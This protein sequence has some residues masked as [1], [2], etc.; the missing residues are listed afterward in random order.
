M[1][2][3]QIL[4]NEDSTSSFAMPD[5]VM[6]GSSSIYSAMPKPQTMLP[7]ITLDA[8]HHHAS[9]VFRPILQPST[10]SN[11]VESQRSSSSNW[12]HLHGYDGPSSMGGSFMIDGDW[13]NTAPTAL[14][15]STA[16]SHSSSLHHQPTSI[17]NGAFGTESPGVLSSA[18]GSSVLSMDLYEGEST[19]T[20]S[21]P[22][23]TRMK[24]QRP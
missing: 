7:N 11:W 10:T 23:A 14:S 13:S 12:S 16:R 21:S 22:V 1:A 15:S 8:G 9:R 17:A 2:S 19:D 18:H 24:K 6:L 4:E 3:T 20:E 5:G